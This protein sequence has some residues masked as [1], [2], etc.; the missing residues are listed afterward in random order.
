[1]ERIANLA[2]NALA[3]KIDASRASGDRRRQAAALRLLEVIELE[4]EIIGIQRKISRKSEEPM[5]RSQREYILNEQLKEI[6]R[7]WAA[8]AARTSSRN[9]SGTIAE[10]NPP[11][12]TLAKARKELGVSKNFR[13]SHPSGRAP[14][15]P[16][17]DRRGL[18][19]ARRPRTPTTSGRGAHF[20]TRITST[21][22][23]R[24]SV[25]SST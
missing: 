24:R 11:P 13:P 1:V 5:D 18:P 3:V 23:R 9:S 7:S 2:C 8:T 6:N 22:A 20:W 17:M 14:R 19:G 15:L 25:S 12:E 16:G 10:K 21:C 4:N